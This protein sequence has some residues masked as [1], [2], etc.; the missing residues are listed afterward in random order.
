MANPAGSHGQIKK[1]KVKFK[2]VKAVESFLILLINCL[3][4]FER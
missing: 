1:P 2:E 3:L 4:P